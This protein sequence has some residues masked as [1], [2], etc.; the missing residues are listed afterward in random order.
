MMKTFNTTGVVM[1]VGETMTFG[2]FQKRTV[3]VNAPNNETSKYPNPLMFTLKKDKCDLANGLNVGDKVTVD[4][5][6]D[7][8]EWSSPDG[9][10]K[11]FT[12]LTVWSIIR[13]SPAVTPVASGKKWADVVKAWEAKGGT[14]DTLKTLLLENYSTLVNDAKQAGVKV[15]A[16]VDE[17]PETAA[18]LIADIADDGGTISN[19]A[20][21]DMP[22]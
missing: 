19:E 4:F 7:G 3:V 18:K 10:T 1:S 9:T 14:M 13:E 12:D 21:E 16:L 6:V 20:Y 15:A 11:Y 8:R 5:T 22:F 2:T 17:R